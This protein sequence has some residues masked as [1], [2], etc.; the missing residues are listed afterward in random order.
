MAKKHNF[1]GQPAMAHPVSKLESS[2]EDDAWRS[3]V[4]EAFFDAYADEDVIY[5]QLL[6]E[7]DVLPVE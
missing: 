6:N 5:E 4:A 3:L 1:D 7:P 2:E